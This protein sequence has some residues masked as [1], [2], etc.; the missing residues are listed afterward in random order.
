VRLRICECE[1]ECVVR[2]SA[3]ALIWFTNFENKNMWSHNQLRLES[4]ITS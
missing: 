3:D 1:C 2:V 4:N